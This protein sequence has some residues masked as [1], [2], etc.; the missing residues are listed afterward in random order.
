MYYGINNSPKATLTAGISAGDQTIPVSNGTFFPAGPNIATIGSDDDAELV[1]YDQVSGNTL[2]G[3]VRG[4]NGT[5][6]KIWNQNDVIYRGYTAHDHAAFKE[7]IE[8]LDESKLA[9]SGAS[10]DTTASFTA[11]EA[12]ANIVSDETL[13]VLFGKIAKWFSDMKALAFKTTVATGDIDAASV[14]NAKLANMAAGTMKGNSSTESGVPADLTG[15]QVRS[16]LNVS[17]GADVTGTTLESTSAVDLIADADKLIIVDASAEAGSRTKHVLW[18]AIKTALGALFAPFQHAARHA[19]T[20]DDAIT[21]ASIG[22]EKERLTFADQSVTTSGWGEYTAA[23][24]EETL[25]KNA[26]F[27]YKKSLSLSG[28]LETMDAFIIPSKNK[29]A[30]GAIINDGV[31]TSNGEIYLYAKSVPTNAFTLRRISCFKAVD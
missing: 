18:S 15:A 20:G 28:V 23:A 27:V 19:A 17:S 4:F 9:S 8:D 25:I 13:S 2:T 7:N 26:G 11:A 16:I 24:G 29:K 22:A 30:C 3:C 31:I 14:T 6:A 5:T 1:L 10:G 21:P 12:R